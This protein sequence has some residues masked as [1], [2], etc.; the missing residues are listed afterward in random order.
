MI[1]LKDR[2]YKNIPNIFPAL[3]RELVGMEYNDETALKDI[4][5]AGQRLMHHLHAPRTSKIQTAQAQWQVA[6]DKYT[7]EQV[8]KGESIKEKKPTHETYVTTIRYLKCRAPYF[9]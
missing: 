7:L 8:L 6:L 5:T 9:I 1:Q 3:Y 2:V 4:G